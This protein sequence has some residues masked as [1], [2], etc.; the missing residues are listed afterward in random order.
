MG[1][2]PGQ[3]VE[4]VIHPEDCTLDLPGGSTPNAHDV[5]ILDAR[6]QGIAT[7]Y[8]VALHGDPFDVLVLGTDEPL[9]SGTAMQLRSHPVGHASCPQHDQEVARSAPSA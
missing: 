6:F 7:R 2:E 9:A 8:T 5:Q 3:A 4:L 1:A